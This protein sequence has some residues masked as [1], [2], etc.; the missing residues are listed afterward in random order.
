M[1]TGLEGKTHSE[2]KSLLRL[3][4]DMRRTLDRGPVGT[5][6]VWG[7]WNAAADALYGL[8]TIEMTRRMLDV[9]LKERR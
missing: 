7:T 5:F 3:A 1:K 6:L 9:C 2:L 4:S 8:A